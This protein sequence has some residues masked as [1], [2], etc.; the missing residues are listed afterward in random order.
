MVEQGGYLLVSPGA[1]VRW[2]RRRL[3]DDVLPQATIAEAA[4]AH[5]G[6]RESRPR[7]ADARP[8]AWAFP[9]P[10]AGARE[11]CEA[12]ELRLDEGACSKPGEEP[13]KKEE[14]AE[15]R[16]PA[17]RGAGEAKW[18][19]SMDRATGDASPLTTNGCEPDPLDRGKKRFHPGPVNGRRCTTPMGIEW[20]GG[21]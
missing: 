4:A 21:R 20:C 19:R 17:E 13:D 7:F 14:L 10:L 2:V 16:E 15:A 6:M 11:H 12:W 8:R 9:L 5:L 1:L 18:I 3:V